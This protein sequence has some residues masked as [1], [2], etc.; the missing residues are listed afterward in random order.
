MRLESRVSKIMRKMEKE[1]RVQSLTFDESSE[2]DHKIAV[3]FSKIKEESE[4]KQRASRAYIADVESGR[5]NFYTQR[6]FYQK[7]K[8]YFSNLF[9]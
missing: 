2:I 3:E 7:F 5:I 8:D 6:T 1:G 4:R 9:K